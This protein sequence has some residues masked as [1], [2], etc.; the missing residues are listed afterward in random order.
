VHRRKERDMKRNNVNK[1]RL[2]RETLHRLGLSSLR[3]AAGGA[4]IGAGVVGSLNCTNVLSVCYS[5]TTPLDTC[6][7]VYTTPAYTCA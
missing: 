7:P 5:C 1:L 6:P 4:A 3:A 2:S